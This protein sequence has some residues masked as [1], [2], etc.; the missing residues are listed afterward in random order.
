MTRYQTGAR[1]EREV[2]NALR[3]KG[4]I[5]IRSAGS[6]GAF[7]LCVIYAGRV[8]LLQLKAGRL[9]RKRMQSLRAEL[10]AAVPQGYYYLQA[11]VLSGSLKEMLEAVEGW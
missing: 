6:K 1:L 11:S 8:R 9:G 5:V 3:R 4:A 10:D 7:D 2:A